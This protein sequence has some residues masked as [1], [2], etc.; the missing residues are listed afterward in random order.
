M[1]H[2]SPTAAV[3]SVSRPPRTL[4]VGGIVKHEKLARLR[5]ETGI[6]LAWIALD[7]GRSAAAVASIA[8]RLRAR[9]IDRVVLLEGLL[10]GLLDHKQS[11]PIVAAA[12]EV[13]APIA[14]ARKG[15]LSSVRQALLDLEL[16]ALAN[17]AAAVRDALCELVPRAMARAR[18]E[19]A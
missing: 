15:G 12:R 18:G 3:R 16:R 4:I 10:E 13:A 14:Y 6:D 11:E 8:S 5:A 2:S 17:A 1:I 19:R 9:R 7:T